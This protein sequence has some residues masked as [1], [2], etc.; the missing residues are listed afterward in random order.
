MSVVYIV[1]HTRVAKDGHDHVKMIGAFATR[2]SATSAVD[3]LR[4][5]PGFSASPNGFS[6]DEYEVD[7]IHWAE[8]FGGV[9]D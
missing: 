6:V 4:N 8:G 7:K 1:Q 3:S 2:D 5:A 9:S